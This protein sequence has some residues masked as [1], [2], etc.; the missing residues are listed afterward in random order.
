M[1]FDASKKTYDEK[2]RVKSGTTFLATTEVGGDR[3]GELETYINTQDG[4]MYFTVRREPPNTGN[5]VKYF[6]YNE[7][8][9]EYS[10]VYTNRFFN[11][12]TWSETSQ[13]LTQYSPWDFPWWRPGS[14][15]YTGVFN[16]NIP[17]FE[18]NDKNSIDKYKENGDTSGA[19]NQ[20][21]LYPKLADFTVNIDGSKNP[22]ITINMQGNEYLN[23][24]GIIRFYNL[25]TSAKTEIEINNNSSVSYTWYELKSMLGLPLLEGATP[26]DLGVIVGIA[27]KQLSDENKCAMEIKPSAEYNITIA[28]STDNIT[29]LKV[30]NGASDSDDSSYQDDKGGDNSSNDE[31]KFSAS[32]LLT[33]TYYLTSERLNTL[34]DFLWGASFMDNIKLLNNSPIE[35]ILSVK[36]MPIQR[37]DGDD[38]RLVIGNVDTGIVAPIVENADI[39]TV[40][41]GQINIP[42]VF[43]NF[44]D[45]TMTTI[46]IYLPYIGFKEIDPNYVINNTLYLRYHFNLIMGTCMAVISKLN[47]TILNIFEGQCGID[48]P[49]TASNR[50]QVEN[51]NII[52]ALSSVADVATGNI[53]GAVSDVNSSLTNQ[54]H[55]TTTGIGSPSL[56]V[57]LKSNAYIIVNRPK[58]FNPTKY[59]HFVGYICNLHKKLSTLKGFTVIENLDVTGVNHATDSEKEMIQSLFASGVYL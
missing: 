7:N 33:K 30:S 39:L 21:D 48:I 38:K 8:N 2:G 54:Y 4:G 35:N 46:T 16:T 27:S 23:D 55:S 43:N 53:T 3:K 41:I 40:D 51:A 22:T 42:S 20:D 10:V 37:S 5:I 57:Q 36:A 6:L 28:D 18:E 13:L 59:G 12:S 29:H 52:N 26:L 17:V 1:P 24:N 25:F 11:G 19:I 34:G 14:A 50:A 47:G 56:M 15:L 9:G 44:I 32:N 45:Y 49:L 58:K 31:N